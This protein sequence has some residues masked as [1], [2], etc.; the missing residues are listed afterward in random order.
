LI[1]GIQWSDGEALTA[2]DSVYAYEVFQTYFHRAAPEVLQVTRSYTA[3]DERTVEWMGIPGYV[4]R[5]STRFFSP[6][7]EHQWGGFE[8]EDLLG[9]E[10]ITR[11]PLGWGPYIL[12]EWVTGDHITMRRNPNYYRSAEGLPHFDFLVYR[13]VENG[14]AA[15][16]ALL[17]GEC[18]LVDRTLLFWENLPRLQTEQAAGRLS[19]TAQL[20]TAWELV[21]FGIDSYDQNRMNIFNQAA[22]RRAA[23]MCINRQQILDELFFGLPPLM[24]SYLPP[25]HSLSNPD[26]TSYPFDPAGARLLL[27]AA[28]WLD[29]DGDPQTSRTAT[30][31]PGI[32]D[33]TPLSFQYLL[34]AG[35]ERP[36]T[37]EIIQ[38]GLES[39]GFQVE[40]LSQDWETLMQPGPD[41][42]LFGRQFDMAQFAWST[43]LEPPC[44]LFITDEIPGPY[45]ESPKGWGGGNLSG[46]SSTDF[47]A[48][49][50]VAQ[51]VIPGSEAYIQA[52]HRAQA[53]FT[54]ELPAFPLYQRIQLLA[55][56]PDICN[57]LVDPSANSALNHLELLDYGTG[58]E[59]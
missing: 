25:N 20:G 28:G 8:L 39:C 43:T 18:D 9:S 19:F 53:I 3:L 34:P 4:G 10:L 49:C 2:A 22:V 40:V 15:L 57:L 29:Q 47:D 56:R 6:L 12:E 30:G 59:D 33:G 36:Q 24:D 27:D 21:A 23:A 41:G 37:A 38:G 32:P 55:A 52:H 58:C 45:P 17:A 54:Q 51:R 26:V 31:V 13:F 42:L 7:P 44:S 14:D 16:N 1:P 46:F 5:V 35:E 50:V 11:N 48:A